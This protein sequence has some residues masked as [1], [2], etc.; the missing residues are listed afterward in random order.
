MKTLL[1]TRD[2]LWPTGR[3]LLPTLLDCLDGCKERVVCRVV[4]T[5]LMLMFNI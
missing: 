5:L 1:N 2:L 4:S 3:S